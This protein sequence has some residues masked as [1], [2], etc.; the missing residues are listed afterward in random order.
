MGR[1]QNS[2]R[3]KKHGSFCCFGFCIWTF[4]CHLREEFIGYHSFVFFSEV[5]VA[6]LGWHF[7]VSL[8]WME[9]TC[10]SRRLFHLEEAQFLQ[11]P[12]SCCIPHMAA[13][14]AAGD[15][16]VL[17]PSKSIVQVAVGGRG[18]KAFCR[19]RVPLVQYL[20]CFQG[21]HFWA[22]KSILTKTEV[23]LFIVA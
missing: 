2:S 10:V 11:F 12:S 23:G 19:S 20:A 4:S 1:F 3:I 16:S 13:Q 17:W 6:G 15:L 21:I 7:K 14:T 5:E 8:M 18:G 22:L 9:E